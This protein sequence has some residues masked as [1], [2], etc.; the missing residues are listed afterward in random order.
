MERGRTREYQHK[1]RASA[2]Y[3]ICNLCTQESHEICDIALNSTCEDLKCDEKYL[4]YRRRL[5]REITRK[6]HSQTIAPPLIVHF[7]IMASGDSVMK[8]ALHRDE[9][10]KSHNVIAFEMESAGIF[11]S[12]PCLVIKGVC[13]YADSHKNKKWQ[14]Y[15]LLRHV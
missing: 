5:N 8:S 7:G 14:G 6:N 1:H 4:V 3:R 10:A 15:L 2:G 9:I 11:E 12:L 13:D